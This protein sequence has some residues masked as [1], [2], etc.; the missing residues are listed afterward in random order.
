MGFFSKLKGEFIDIIEWLDDSNDT[1][2]YRFERYQNEIKNGAKLTVR[3][4]QVAVFINEGKVADIFSPGMYTLNTENLPIL[5]TLKGW[6]FGFNSP[7]KAE[8]YFVSTRKITAQKWGTKNPITLSDA[9]FGMLEIRAFGTYVI[10]VKNA[11]E[12][13]TEI[14]GTDG[15]FTTDEIAEQL[16]SMIVTRFTDCV[17]ESNLPIENYASNANEISEYVH[18]ILAPE[19]EKYGIEVT[20]FLI[21]NVSMPEEIKKEIFELSRLN[22]IDLDKLAKLKAAKAI[23]KA[24]E[25][26][27][28]TAGAGMGMGMGFAMAN[29]MG[30][31]FSPNQQSNPSPAK[32]PSAPPPIPAE[33]TFHVAVD[34]KQTGPF[35]KETIK[36]MVINNQLTK[37]ALVWREG[38]ANW[39]AASEVSEL[40]DIFGS[41]PP[42]IPG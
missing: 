22:T 26:D 14:V 31:T 12:F 23:E 35:N 17:G 8:V 24:A 37:E 20:K 30:Q 40:N 19:F 3:E 5:S 25:N 36:Q 9:R 15:E 42:P 38:M 21:E 2:V 39:S 29:Q 34:G 1:L 18:G 10:R 11:P 4:G 33:I 41:V 27:S 6:K 32:A 16:K 13:I 7:F 28:G